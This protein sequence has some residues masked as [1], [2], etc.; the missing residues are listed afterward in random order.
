LILAPLKPSSKV[1][2]AMLNFK[3]LM[4]LDI[5]HDTFRIVDLNIIYVTPGGNLDICN[6]SQACQGSTVVHRFLAAIP[7]R[8]K[9][10][11]AHQVMCL[12]DLLALTP[13][14]LS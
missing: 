12:I 5:R 1:I 11:L 3:F 9:N 2:E 10:G 8:V 4:S 13:Y 6:R 7:P 14:G